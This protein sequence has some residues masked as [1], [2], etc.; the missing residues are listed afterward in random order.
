M[1]C[2]GRGEAPG[3]CSRW[4][5]DG[6]ADH[7]G[8]AAGVGREGRSGEKEGESMKLR[9]T[10]NEAQEVLHKVGVLADEPELLEGY[11]LTE[12]QGATLLHSIPRNGGEWVVALEFVDA[13]R[14]EMQDHAIVLRDI[15]ED[16][17]NGGEI[18][19]SL[20]IHR[21]AARFEGTFK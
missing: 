20:T 14:G 1:R 11:G 8:T 9:L 13:V 21:L 3:P 12:A 17:R 15:A 7:P 5:G 18:G 4:Q 16:A 2:A 6:R 19:Q 10:K